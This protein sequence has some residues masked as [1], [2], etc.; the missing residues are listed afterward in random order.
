MGNDPRGE[1]R[2]FNPVKQA[3]EYDPAGD[4]VRRWLPELR[5][6]DRLENL[7]QP[8]TTP[9]ED[10][11]RLGL[12]GLEMAE[13]PV[14]KIDFVVEG[15][16]KS[17]RRPFHRRHG[18][19]RGGSGSG[20]GNTDASGQHHG[21]APASD[22]PAAAAQHPGGAAYVPYG[23]AGTFVNY[24]GHGNA[25][26]GFRGGRGPG[27]RGRGNYGGGRGYRGGG[28]HNAGHAQSHAHAHWQHGYMLPHRPMQQQWVPSF[29][30]PPH[31]HPIPHPHPHPHMHPHP[32]QHPIPPP[33]PPPPQ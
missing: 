11:A 2:I 23:Q 29:I 12:E 19:G 24:S 27:H 28:R 5:A 33:P 18:R 9:R 16:P 3:F 31:P 22:P 13:N 10:W 15:K 4:Y 6:L 20:S 26:G 32:H 25:R 17:S 8:W 21:Q 1:A 14:K 7:F 30:P